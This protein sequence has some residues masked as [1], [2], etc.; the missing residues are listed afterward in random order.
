MLTN[1][2]R[3]LTHT[4]DTILEDEMLATARDRAVELG[5][6]PV[7]PPV[8]AALALHTALLG[9]RVADPGQRDAATVAVREAAR[10]IADD[11]RLT[12]VLFPIGDG[13][14]CAARL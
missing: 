1:A 8:G 5:A 6:A 14:L 11:E 7:P 4:E 12:R 13:L 2:E 10:A 3:I 9:G